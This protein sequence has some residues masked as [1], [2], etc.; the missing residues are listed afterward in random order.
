MCWH[1]LAQVSEPLCESGVTVT[2]PVLRRHAVPVATALHVNS[3]QPWKS[4]QELQQSIGD[5]EP[6]MRPPTSM[7]P[8]PKSTHGVY[9]HPSDLKVSVQKSQSPLRSIHLQRVEQKSANRQTRM[10][11]DCMNIAGEGTYT[12]RLRLGSSHIGA[13]SRQL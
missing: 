6:L 13:E 7:S 12:R 2:P 9:V 11:Q 3:V 10:L 8:P 1:A 5:G 4:L